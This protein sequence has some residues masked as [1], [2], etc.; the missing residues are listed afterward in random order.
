MSEQDEIAAYNNNLKQLE[1]MEQPQV[2]TGT[3]NSIQ[4]NGTYEGKYGM[5][6][7]YM[8]GFTNG[9]VGEYSSKK[10]TVN[11]VPFKVGS[12]SNYEFTDGKFPKVKPQLR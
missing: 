1:Q 11:D 9:D 2:K 3:V 5:L 10:T 4:A 7:K 12:E 8:I 6:Y